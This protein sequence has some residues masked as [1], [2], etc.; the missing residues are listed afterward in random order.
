MAF[1]KTVAG[2]SL[3]KGSVD[4]GSLNEILESGQLSYPGP[5]GAD[6]T[7][8]GPAGPAGAAGADSTVPGPAGAAGADS[9]VPGP[10]GELGGFNSTQTTQD[11]LGA[12]TLTLSDAGKIFTNNDGAATIT[13][14]GLSSGQ[15]ADFLQTNVEKFTFVAGS[16]ITLFSKNNNLKTNAQYSPATVKCVGTNTYVLLGDLGA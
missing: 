7:V 8:P 9:T 5:A 14:Q 6:S 11:L 13:V 15:Q 1:R 16:G 3:P 4:I 2:Y 10:A 12:Y